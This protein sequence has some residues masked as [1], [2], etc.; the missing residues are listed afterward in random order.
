MT[1]RETLML[2]FMR[3][4]V[5]RPKWCDFRVEIADAADSGIANSTKSMRI[6][7]QTVLQ[8]SGSR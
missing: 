7:D 4:L 2:N 8:K 6:A 3:S 1:L 5:L